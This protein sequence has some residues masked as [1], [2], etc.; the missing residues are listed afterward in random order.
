[1]TLA[2]R[3][4]NLLFDRD[5]FHWHLPMEF[6]AVDHWPDDRDHVWMPAVC[7]L[8]RTLSANAVLGH[9]HVQDRF[10]R[11]RSSIVCLVQHNSTEIH[12]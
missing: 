9:H 11:A 8:I 3:Y 7:S 10:K 5:D 4:L 12:S 1:M 6:L 2:V